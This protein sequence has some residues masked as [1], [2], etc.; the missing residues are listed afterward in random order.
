MI[1][2]F[3]INIDFCCLQNVRV[4]ELYECYIHAEMC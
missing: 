4:D 1:L 3:I 2:V